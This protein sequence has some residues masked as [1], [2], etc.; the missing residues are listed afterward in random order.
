MSVIPRRRSAIAIV[1]R[2]SE[3]S[4]TLPLYACD[5]QKMS[6]GCVIAEMFL[7]TKSLRQKMPVA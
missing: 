6:H 4:A 2:S 7:F 5:S 1:S 3:S